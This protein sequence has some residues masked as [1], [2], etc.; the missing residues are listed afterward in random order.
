MLEEGD[1][2]ATELFLRYQKI[3]MPNLRLEK[4]EID[5]L[6]EHMR[7]ESSRI[8]SDFAKYSESDLPPVS[9]E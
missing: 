9:L 1:P 8:S 6:I 3:A 7:L 5:A 2:T 4:E